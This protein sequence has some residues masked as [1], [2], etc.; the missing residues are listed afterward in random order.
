MY[1]VKY[2]T[3]SGRKM[4][5]VSVFGQRGLGSNLCLYSLVRFITVSP[6]VLYVV[7]LCVT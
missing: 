5:P 3:V 4:D 2:Y 1:Q 6:H 7:G